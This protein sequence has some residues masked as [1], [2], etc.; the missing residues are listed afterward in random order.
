MEEEKSAI[1]YDFEAERERRKI[2]KW[3]GPPEKKIPA[4]TPEASAIS[5][6]DALKIAQRVKRKFARRG[7]LL[8][9]FLKR[10]ETSDFKKKDTT[11]LHEAL[12][13]Q[14]MMVSVYATPDLKAILGQHAL[15][16]DHFDG[17][18]LIAVAE[19]FIKRLQSDDKS[20]R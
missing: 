8:I 12:Y 20:V 6:E 15:T 14:R 18:Y 7:A 9:D 2:P 5:L 4:Y 3:P 13:A 17:V 19:E 1:L 11:E 16:P 10:R